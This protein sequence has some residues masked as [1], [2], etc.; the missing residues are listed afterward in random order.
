[1]GNFF[2]NIVSFFNKHLIIYFSIVLLLIASIF[3]GIS[4]LKFDEN[5]YSIFPQA[6]EF[7]EFNKILKQ[8]N[9]NKQIIFSVDV[10][11]DSPEELINRLDSISKNILKCTDGLVVDFEYYREDN[12]SS[13][14]SY[15][16]QNFPAYLS[17]NDFEKIELKLNPDSIYSSIENADERLMSYNSLFFKNIISIDPL[18]IAGSKL[19][20]VN[21][22]SSNS[23]FQFED[24]LIYSDNGE[25]VIFNASLGFELDDIAK[26]KELNER[27]EL[28]KIDLNSTYSNN[29]DYFGTFQISYENSKQVKLDVFVTMIFSIA[30]ILIL[31]IIYY[32]NLLVPFYFLFPAVFSGFSGLA[33]VGYINP[34]ISVISVATSA[35]LFGI[36]LDYSFHFFTHYKYSQNIEV[37]IK[38]ITFPML[39]GSFTTVSAFS[40]LMFTDSLV[41]QNFGLIALCTLTSAV[42]FNLLIFPTFLKITRFKIKLSIR[43]VN[44]NPIPKVIFRLVIFIIIITTTFFF[45]RQSEF[46]F[47]SDLNNLNYHSKELIQKEKFYAGINPKEDKKIHL[48]ITSKSRQE[49]IDLNFKLYEDLIG[50]KLN[51]GLE[52][53]VSVA[54]YL[55]P[56]EIKE[57]RHQNWNSFW[58]NRIDSTILNIN[59]AS[60]KFDFSKQAFNPFEKWVRGLLP[61][62]NYDNLMSNLGLDKY[63]YK[64]QNNWNIITSVV[65]KRN[66]IDDFRLKF[67]KHDSVFIFDVSEMANNLLISVQNDF[68][69]LL[70]FSSLLVFISLFIIYGR[71]EIALFSFLPMVISWIWIISIAGIFNIQFNF[72]NILVA[73]FIF[74]LGDDFSIFITDGLIQKYKTRSSSIKSYRSAIILS[75]ITT[76]IGTGSLYFA[77]HP[78]IHSIAIISIVGIACI[79][80]VTLFVQPSIFSFFILNRTNQKKSPVTFLGLIISIFLF[81]Y[82]VVGCL[83]INLFL[84]ILIPF[85]LH[86]VYKR[87]LLNFII[88]KL[89][90][91]TIYLGFHVN[92]KIINIEKLNFEKPSIIIAN[93]SSFLDILLMIM[94]SPK[95]IIMVKKWV[96]NSPIFG[97][98]IRY[99]GYLFIPEGADYNIDKI[100]SKIKDGY[101]I[102][103]FPEGSRSFDGNIQRFHKG[104]FYLAQ[105]LK[106]DIQPILIV[107]ANYVNKKNDFIIKS[108]E[109]ILFVLDRITPNHDSFKKRF[110]LFAKDV[111]L[112][113]KKSHK[114]VSF[115]HVNTGGLKNRVLYNFLYKSP[116][117]E[118]YI[119]IKW[120]IES[121]NFE[122]YDNLI[123]NRKR[124]YDIGCGYGYL[125][126]Y[127]HYRDESRFIK[128]IDYDEEKIIIAQNGYDKTESLNFEVN[129]IRGLLYQSP[130]VVIFNDVLHYISLEDQYKVLS[131]V[132]NSL[133]DN[134]II[135]IRD[136]ISDLSRRH[137][138]TR[139]TEKYSTKILRFNK[140]SQGLSYFTSESIFNFAKEHNFNCKM[141]QQSKKTSNVLFILR[142]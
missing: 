1:M 67:G 132:A 98:F 27:L 100:H 57:V 107:G 26:N 111:S 68:N 90:K 4:R 70:I 138:I 36:I 64:T 84:L 101:S 31:L 110:G 116:I 139:I 94:L 87:K 72:V 119:R 115:S 60:I 29:F 74:G 97:F 99:S 38:K 16:Y 21:Q 141:V 105:Q 34:N 76:I 49:A 33:L 37:T 136:G 85:P 113:M 19:S 95:V 48:F 40:A 96:Y 88:S 30:L 78:A 108:G 11:Q 53:I 35:V 65:I 45:I 133:N 17:S 51:N 12:H 83:I 118:W 15:F 54:P 82:F 55:I 120:R 50:F 122:Y 63:I 79:M 102:V 43:E 104:A 62:E 14:L 24:G 130:D 117:I 106:L 61:S 135:L 32:K 123:Q 58:S 6:N 13:I 75:G 69:Y 86:K 25:K 81:T 77:K 18:N 93:H 129:D 46:K 137:K 89:A 114:E 7:K 80:L 20:Y 42:F 8:N 52:E 59:S 124:I 28:F 71:I 131:E 41:L 103:I 121:N 2:F 91:S 125:S 66:R 5:I 56:E 39:V 126:Y 128:G 47:N 23:G 134:G 109:L 142:K 73:T 44:T 10:N 92:K 140:T 9:L 22:Y 112:I 3:F 127:L